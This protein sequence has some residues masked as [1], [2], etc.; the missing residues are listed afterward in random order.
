MTEESM[1]QALTSLESLVNQL[2][3]GEL[4]LD[5]AIKVFEQGVAQVAALRE[6]LD[7]AELR[8]REVL[9]RGGMMQERDLA[10]EEG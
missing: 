10:S 3:S 9:E 5:E 7:Q 1:D 4:T 2:E 6:R 8:V